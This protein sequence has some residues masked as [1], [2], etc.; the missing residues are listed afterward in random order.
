MTKVPNPTF[1]DP[2]LRWWTV[3]ICDFVS[4]FLTIPQ[5][6]CVIFQCFLTIFSCLATFIQFNGAIFQCLATFIQFVCMIFQCLTELFSNIATFVVW[7]IWQFEM[8]IWENVFLRLPDNE[9]GVNVRIRITT[10]IKRKLSAY[11]DNG[12]LI[13]ARYCVRRGISNDDDCIKYLVWKR[14]RLIIDQCRNKPPTGRC[15]HHKRICFGLLIF[16][17]RIC[18]TCFNASTTENFPRA[19]MMV[20]KVHQKFMGERKSRFIGQSTRVQR[21]SV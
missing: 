14:D 15:R 13:Q 5:F 3:K 1:L 20:W 2:K 4:C 9:I 17:H 18:R 16:S 8:W 6:V 7:Y 11:T 12:H 21:S 10:R 19:S